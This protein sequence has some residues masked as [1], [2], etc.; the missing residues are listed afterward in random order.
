MKRVR[1]KKE[2]AGSVLIL[3][4]VV[5]VML[6][7]VGLMAFRTVAVEVDVVG[8]ERKGESALYIAEAGLQYGLQRIEAYG[9][10]GVSPNYGPITALPVVTT[11]GP[12]GPGD[13]AGY[14]E[15]HSTDT[16]L[17]YG[18]GGFRVVVRPVDPPNDDHL[19]ILCLGI[20]GNPSRGAKRL[21]E[22]V[23]RPGT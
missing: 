20:S 11:G 2:E 14:F 18:D 15:L 5:I 19:S 16:F 22:V 3:A 9:F 8:A 10:S 1:I 21:L 13:M 4:T 7:L 23:V 17:S 12:W 6:T